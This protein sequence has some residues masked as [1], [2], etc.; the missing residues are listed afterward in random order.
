MA[1]LGIERLRRE[2][3]RVRHAM[4]A[5]DLSDC[6]YNFDSFPTNCCHHA[7]KLLAIHLGAGGWGDLRMAKGCHDAGPVHEHV[8]LNVGDILVDLTADQ[9]G[10]GLGPVI[11]TRHS[12]WHDAW[13]PEFEPIKDSSLITWKTAEGPC[14]TPT[15]SCLRI[16]SNQRGG[17]MA[18]DIVP[19]NRATP[20]SD[21]LPAIV[22]AAGAGWVWEEF[23][24]GQLRN[25]HTRRAYVRAVRH[26]LA[27]AEGEGVTLKQIAPGQVGKYLDQLGGSIP[28]KKLHLAALRRFFDQLVVRHVVLL[29]PAASVCGERYQVVEGKTPELGIDNA[30]TLLKRLDERI[31]QARTEQG[32]GKHDR[33]LVALRDR[34]VI[35]ML[36]YT[37]ARR[38]AVATLRRGDLRHDGVQH[39][40]RF[41]EKGGKERA[42]PV[43]HELERWLLAYVEAAGLGNAPKD[44]PLFR[45]AEGKT[46]KLSAQSITGGDVGRLV[47]RR[48]KDAGLPGDLSP[49]SFRVTV[50]TDLLEQGQPLEDV[51]HLA[52][53]VDPRTTRLY[54]RRQKKATRKLVEKISV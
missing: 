24:S 43:H 47:K 16:W 13:H 31:D 8:W 26:F 48:L 17:N 33:T 30:R 40:L 10:D 21:T 28:K 2:A 32:E 6:G 15:D 44:S 29:N 35:G 49:H 50:I 38:E 25:P 19:I 23:F 3:A 12:P 9:F 5:T 53:H 36:I 27:W 46:G 22:A 34:A 52:G 39:L 41:T 18:S 14:S 45:S 11:V 4:E 54:D 37:A 7:V 1:G 51:Q 42:I 20:P